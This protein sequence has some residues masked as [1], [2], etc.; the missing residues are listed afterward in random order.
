MGKGVGVNRRSVW[1]TVAVGLALA[2]A[3][4]CGSGGSKSSDKQSAEAPESRRAPAAEVTV[5]LG[6]INSIAAQVGL[7][8]S[9]DAKSAKELNAG[10]EPAWQAIEGTVRANDKD[11]YIRF[12]DDFAALGKAAAAG[13]GTK[14]QQSAAE[15]ADAVKTYL[16]KFPG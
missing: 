16:A 14:A 3:G 15:I 12:E 7:A 13:D 10:I 9:A 2:T 4:A 5:G 6:K 11:L 8:A 1:R